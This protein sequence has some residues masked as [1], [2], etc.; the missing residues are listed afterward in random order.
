MKKTVLITGASSGFGKATA[1]LFAAR[2]WNVIATMRTPRELP[3]TFVTRLDVEKPETIRAAV[4]AGLAKFR[5]IDAVVNNAGYG[6]SGVFE[7]TPDEKVREQFEVNVFGVMNVVRA[8]LPHF[9][10]NKGG[11]IVNVSSGAGVFGLPLISL[12][13]ASKFALEGFSESLSYELGALGIRVKLVEPGG[14]T[15]TRFVER[16]AKEASALPGDVRDYAAFV[17]AANQVF[18][19][20]RASRGVDKA[21]TPEHVAEVIFEATNDASDRLRYVA[22]NDILPLVEARRQTSET[23]YMAFMRTHFGP[24]LPLAMN[25]TLLITGASGQLG[26]RVLHHLLESNEV[27]PAR[28]IATTREPARLAELAARGV[29]VRHADFNDAASLEKAFAGADRILIISTD[30]LDLVGG[31]RLRQHE[32]AV[33]V[34]RKVGA[35]HLAYTSMLSPEPGSPFL[36][37]SDHYGTEQALKASGLSYTIFR[38][39]S[40]FENL[41]WS[42]PAIIATGRWH[43]SA[44]EG[45][46]AY[47]A[48]DDMAA[49][50]ASHLASAPNDSTTLM[51]TGSRAYSHAEV[52]RL[53]TEVTG[54]PIELVPLSDEALTDTL[55]AS[56]VPEPFARLRASVDANVR[57]GNSDPVNDTLETLSRRKPMSLEH[58]LDTN[59]AALMGG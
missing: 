34:A 19:A 16:S 53:V 41:M 40:Y 48:R 59:R 50:I 56:G 55:I 2:G 1:E 8:V 15:S 22:T 4:D 28:I 24:R 11:C 57:A 45:R 18:A 38:T 25:Q 6:L 31:K 27:S 49:A 46:V 52:A 12:Y 47:S 7:L 54:K 17:S 3:G 58:F 32:T 13:T 14:V 20:M 29:S 36:L 35:T 43:T 33:A 21:A 5:R 51:L 39:N 30:E 9:R 44:G 10:E 26:R 42:L 37:A 23:E